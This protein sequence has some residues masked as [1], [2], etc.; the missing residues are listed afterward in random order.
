[1]GGKDS[2]VDNVGAGGAAVHVN[3]DGSL[4]D[5]ASDKYCGRVYS[6]PA[7]PHLKFADMGPVPH[8][9][10]IK[11]TIRRIAAD[12]HYFRI[13]GFDVC[14]DIHGNMR[15]IEINFGGLGTIFQMDSGS[16][17]KKYTDEVIDYC[18]RKP[19][20]GLPGSQW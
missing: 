17:F 5:F 13:L 12:Y 3:D 16:L 14:V 10:N 1:M 19:H 18:A 15:I 2:P 8:Y 4:N 7:A 11:K 6:P 9:E 20:P